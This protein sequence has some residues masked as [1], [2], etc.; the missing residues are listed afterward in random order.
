MNQEKYGWYIKTL[1][2]TRIF[3]EDCKKAGSPSEGVGVSVLIL[4]EQKFMEGL[5]SEAGI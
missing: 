5:E 2:E 3:I 4:L 1:A